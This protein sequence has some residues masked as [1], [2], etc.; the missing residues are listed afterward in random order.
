M[1][2]VAHVDGFAVL[3]QGIFGDLGSHLQVMQLRAAV[4]E[5]ATEAGHF[6]A[7]E[8]IGASADG[9]ALVGMSHAV[10][11]S[12]IE[13][14]EI[15]GCGAVRGAQVAVEAEIVHFCPQ[16]FWVGG[17]VRIVA[18]Q[19]HGRGVG[20]V[21]MGHLIGLMTF[22]ADDGLGG[23][24]DDVSRALVDLDAVTGQASALQRGVR[25]VGGG[26][27]GMTF[28]AIGMLID[29]SMRGAVAGSEKEPCG[30]DQ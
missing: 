15:A 30:R 14:G 7:G 27:V 9:M 12:E 1:A 28:D 23:L 8:G 3:V 6:G 20:E 19:A 16:Q 18:A 21:H 4:G 17:A 24:E 11:H 2:L 29:G 5:V 10:V 22:A 25:M 26:V 13:R